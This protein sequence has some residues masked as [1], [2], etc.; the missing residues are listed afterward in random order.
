MSSAITTQQFAEVKRALELG[1]VYGFTDEE[2]E[3]VYR[4]SQCWKITITKGAEFY[5]DFLLRIEN[6][7]VLVGSNLYEF[8]P[9]F[10]PIFSQLFP[11]FDK[12]WEFIWIVAILGAFTPLKTAFS[13]SYMSPGKPKYSPKGNPAQPLDISSSFSFHNFWRKFPHNIIAPKK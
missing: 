11:N 5:Y 6:G 2:S 9:N 7:S 10:S 1:T 8:Y 4:L 12:V 3:F 13:E